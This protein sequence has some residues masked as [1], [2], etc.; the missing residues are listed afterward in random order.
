MVVARARAR[1]EPPPLLPIRIRQEH[2]VVAGP[3]A[4]GQ[5]ARLLGFD[6]QDQTRIATAVSEIARNV[7]QY[8]GG[9]RSSSCVEGKTAPQV[10]VIR[11]SDR[12]PGI[13]DLARILAGR[14]RSPTGMG[15]GHPRRAPADGP[16]RDRVRAG[17]RDHGRAPQAPAGA[18]PPVL[19]P[20]RLG[21]LARDLARERLARPAWPRCSSRTRSCCAPWTTCG[22]RQE[23]LVRLNRE[24]ED[25]NR[26]VVALYAELDEKADHLRR[27]DEMKSRFLSN[28]SHEFRTPLNSILALAVSSWTART[29]TSR[30]SRRSRSVHPQ[31]GPGPVGAGQRP[32]RPG[33]GGGRQDRRAAGR[34]RGR[35]P[36][37][38]PA[39]AC[40]ARCWPATPCRLVFDEPAG[41]PPLQTDEAK[42]SQILRNFISNALKFTERGE[43]RV[44]AAMDPGAP[45]RWPSRSPT[46]ASASPAEDQERIFQEFGQVDSPL[47]KRVKGTGLGLPLCRRL[48]ELLGGRSR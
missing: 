33:Q 24:L 43:V 27:A 32:P 1:R 48:A 22:S 25:T 35:G 3:P 36:V 26:G 19:R 9:A 16:V 31:G 20:R 17:E 42:V 13:A 29:A 28:M 4:A 2:D 23:E 34:L 44:S 14:Y 10:L 38:R 12:G 30:R 21:R 5:I 18:A 47:Q 7:F 46:P 11:V 41:L 37:R 40:C 15:L 8:A 6:A 39:R 45:T